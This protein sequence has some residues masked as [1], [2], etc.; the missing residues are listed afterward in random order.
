MIVLR[1]EIGDVL[2]AARQRQGRTL[3]QV[4][5]AARV[6]L[7]YLSEI[8]RGQKEASSELLGAI[9]EALDVPMSVVLREVSDRLAVAE[10]LAIP[11]TVPAE[12]ERSIR[13][14]SGGWSPRGE[15]VRAG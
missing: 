6:S 2:R 11:D 13:R 7:G 9:C 15:L 12:L 3:R 8:E 10:G 4:S 14:A 1:R 5:S